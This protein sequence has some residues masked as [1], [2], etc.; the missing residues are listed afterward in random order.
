MLSDKA[1]QLRQLG[2]GHCELLLQR[3]DLGVALSDLTRER[4]E[5]F[6]SP[7]AVLL[8]RAAIDA[9]SV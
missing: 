7:Q 5:L 9:S 6:L 2:L 8:C 3:L 4:L 1:R